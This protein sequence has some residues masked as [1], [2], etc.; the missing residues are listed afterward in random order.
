MPAEGTIARFMHQGAPKRMKT[1]LSSP[2][3]L[4]PGRA[5]ARPGWGRISPFARLPWVSVRID[6]VRSQRH[7]QLVEEMASVRYPTANNLLITADGGSDGSRVRLWK[8]ELQKPTDDLGFSI[9][10]FKAVG[11]PKQLAY[12]SPL[13]ALCGWRRSPRLLLRRT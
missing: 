5:Q 10:V 12:A 9:P 4:A 7:P 6:S 2:Q 8:I 13:T 3:E 11:Q 1:P